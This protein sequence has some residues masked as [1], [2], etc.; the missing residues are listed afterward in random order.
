[1]P[2]DILCKMIPPQI[3]IYECFFDYP[4]H[5]TTKPKTQNLF[6]SRFGGFQ[7]YASDKLTLN[8]LDHGCFKSTQAT[9]LRCQPPAIDYPSITQSHQT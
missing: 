9:D 1:M 6:F 5:Q 3:S 4:I 2:R 7:I 8:F